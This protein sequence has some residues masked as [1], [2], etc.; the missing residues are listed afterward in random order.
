MKVAVVLP[1]YNEQGNLAPL[2]TMLAALNGRD[3]FTIRIIVVNDGSTDGTAEELAVLQSTISG[4]QVVQHPTNLGFARALKTGIATAC[5]D[6][7]DVAV[8]MDAD[9]SHRV[10]DV[11]SLVAA[12]SEGADIALGSRFVRGGGM[13]GVPLWR[14]LISRAGNAL[15]KVV[16]GLPVRDLTTGYRAVRRTVFERIALGEDGFTIQLESVVKAYAAGFRVVEVPI[17]LG[18]RRHGMSHMN[19]STEL[20]RDYWRL[21]MSCRRWVRETKPRS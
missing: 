3:R 4:L 14:V 12:I 17:V 16:L 18:T 10:E 2:I 15:G 1:A 20:F 9:L 6:G 8:F 7:C 19:Y 21:L 11:Q 13:E 5:D